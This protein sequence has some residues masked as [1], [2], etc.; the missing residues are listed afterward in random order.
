MVSVGGFRVAT[1]PV[2]M[3]R[4]RGEDEA[5]GGVVASAGAEEGD[6]EEQGLP[7]GEAEEEGLNWVLS[8]PG[9]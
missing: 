8:C 9:G 2:M 1:E 5:G 6:E 3:A 4:L 7:S